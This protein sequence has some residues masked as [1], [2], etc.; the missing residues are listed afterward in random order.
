MP[1]RKR[2]FEHAGDGILQGDPLDADV[3][4]LGLSRVGGADRRETSREEE[5]HDLVVAAGGGEDAHERLPVGG[6]QIGLFDKLALR[7]LEGDSPAMSSSPAGISQS[8]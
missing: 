5:V 6:R 4:L 2:P 1:L 7:G 3:G 8:R